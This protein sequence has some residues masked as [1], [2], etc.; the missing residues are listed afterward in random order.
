MSIKV[1]VII[2]GSVIAALG[3]ATARVVVIGASAHPLA[4][5][6]ATT[7]VPESPSTS[8]TTTTTTA[9]RRVVVWKHPVLTLLLSPPWR[10]MWEDPRTHTLIRNPDYTDRLPWSKDQL[11]FH[12]LPHRV[13]DPAKNRGV[14]LHGDFLLWLQ[15]HPFLRVGRIQ[16]LR[17]G[18]F[19][20]TAVDGKVKHATQECGES[21]SHFPCVPITVDPDPEGFV[22]FSLEPGEIF[23]II[24][25]RTPGRS[26]V[27][28]IATKKP[29]PFQ[30]AAMRLLRTLRSG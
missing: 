16:H 2:G 7:A 3:V 10:F 22:S 9:T 6:I 14:V 30:G 21:M 5:P 1:R 28:E 19:V 11:I 27:M 25:A 24:E 15:R 8:T 4:E 20:A 17:L 23:R 29:Q 13:Y 12:A 18:K 26:V